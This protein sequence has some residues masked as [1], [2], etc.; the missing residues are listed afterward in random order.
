M[1][2]RTPR[3]DAA[4]AWLIADVMVGPGLIMMAGLPLLYMYA[5]ASM[6]D[7]RLSDR[8]YY[9]VLFGKLFL[10]ESAIVTVPL[11]LVFAY[12]C[13]R[14]LRAVKEIVRPT[15]DKV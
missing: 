4:A 3:S 10:S 13:F 7:P 9:A 6:I 5:F 11:V 2:N 8:E 1:A 14:C 12:G 15:V